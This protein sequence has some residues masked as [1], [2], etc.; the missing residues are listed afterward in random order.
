[1]HKSH[2]WFIVFMSVAD[3]LKYM[4]PVLQFLQCLNPASIAAII[5]HPYVILSAPIN[6]LSLTMDD[7]TVE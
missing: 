5:K 1:M 2:V 3:M 6:A 4:S 7:F